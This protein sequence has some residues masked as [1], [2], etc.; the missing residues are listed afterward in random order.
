MNT[1]LQKANIGLGKRKRAVARVFLVP[2]EGN[3]IINKLAGDKYLH[4]GFCTESPK[5]VTC[6]AFPGRWA[7][8]STQPW[9]VPLLP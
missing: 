4:G 6:I 2:G 7:Q 8:P 3:L 9:K 5:G 1:K